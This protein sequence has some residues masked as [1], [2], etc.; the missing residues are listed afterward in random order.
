MARN[1]D[2]IGKAL[3]EAK[4]RVSERL[5]K[6]MKEGRLGEERRKMEREADRWWKG[7]GRSKRAR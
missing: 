2:P 1:A 7:N 3:K 5:L 4:R 6:A